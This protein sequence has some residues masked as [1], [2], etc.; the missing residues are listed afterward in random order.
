MRVSRSKIPAAFIPALDTRASFSTAAMWA[1]YFDRIS[2]MRG[3]GS[4]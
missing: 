2:F 1:R 4:R 3:E